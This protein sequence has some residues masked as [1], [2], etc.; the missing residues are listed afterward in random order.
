MGVLFCGVKR[1]MTIKETVLTRKQAAEDY[2]RT[3]R[4]MWDQV[5]QL[6]HNQLNDSISNTTKSQVFDPKLTTLT[7]ERGYRVMSQLPTGKVK[8][9][10][11]NDMG[12]AK[13]MNMVLDKYVIPNANA[14]FDFLTKLRMIDIYSNLYGNFFAMV[15]WDVRP[16]GYIGPDLWMLNIRD[17]FPQV[18]AISLEDSD[19]VITR[20]WKPLSYFE[21]LK[22]QQG[23]KNI[24]EI[25]SKLK[26]VS[27]DKQRRETHATSQ[28][29][30]KQYPHGEAAK[31]AGYFEVLTMFERDRWVDYVVDADLEFRDQKNPHDNGELPVVCKYSIPLIDDF[32]GMGDFERGAPMQMAINSVWNL[33]LD[34]VKMSIFPPIM[35]NKDNIA[36]MSS[37][38]WGAAEKWL[39]RN[40]IGN[41]V[42]PIQLTP[43]GISTFNNTYQVA[44]G[45]L[46]NMFGTTD[47]TITSQTEAGFGK[48]PQ[49]LSMQAQRENTRDN[50]DRF[51]MEQFLKK[52]MTKMANL[53]GKKQSK[54]IT[55]RLFDED[56]KELERSYP[57][58]MESYDDKTGK[59]MVD[60]KKTGSVIYDYEMV[61]GST[62]AADTKSQQD[63]LSMLL[64]LYM[65]AQGPQGNAIDALL[66]A[67]GYDFKFGELL[68][69]L[70]SNTG[71]QDWDKILTERSE[72]EQ[73][74][75]VMDGHAQ[76]F[77]QVLQQ[78]GGQQPNMN[79]IP[80]MSGQMPQDQGIPMDPMQQMGGM[81]HV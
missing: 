36:S 14:Q 72:Q 80:P 43:Q 73:G 11:K 39:V 1:D 81:P 41:A 27:G 55:I 28:R 30:V 70:I 5:E 75:A 50:A 35:I 25:V 52:V 26:D 44:N 9:I 49:A 47:T 66:N 33:Y 61:S 16:N 46:L 13:L 45:S 56:L 64:E 74:Q 68:K 40:Q 24:G 77:A 54:A 51:Y 79:A 57:D 71:I 23:F 62:F 19:Y 67:E 48:T 18:G 63:N 42:A 7:L 20:T 38:K 76:Q 69:R 65:K 53:V 60:K 31:N 59:L 34:A 21:G 22:K 4:T 15:D 10:S 17:V 58:L 6:F 78:M 8:A 37:I 29:E 12:T 32:M 3:K 2:L